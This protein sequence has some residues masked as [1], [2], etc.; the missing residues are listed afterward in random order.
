MGI[1]SEGLRLAGT[2]PEDRLLRR[3]A[4][5]LLERDR[6]LRRIVERLRQRE[7]VLGCSRSL[8]ACTLSRVH[9]VTCSI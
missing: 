7:S 6:S 4:G 9:T 8:G 2:L 1:L 3:M 5:R